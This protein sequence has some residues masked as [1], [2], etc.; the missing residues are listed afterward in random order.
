LR[1]RAESRIGRRR[2]VLCAI[3][4]Y[5]YINAISLAALNSRFEWSALRVYGLNAPGENHGNLLGGP[6]WTL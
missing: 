3:Q 4:V 1:A 2:R 5:E 6:G